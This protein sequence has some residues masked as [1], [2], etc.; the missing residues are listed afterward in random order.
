MTLTPAVIDKWSL[1]IIA[2]NGSLE[3]YISSVN[4]TPM[5]T[6]AE[7]LELAAR[8]QEHGDLHAAHHLVLS[9]LRVVVSVARSYAGYGL[10]HADL[11]QEGNIGLM[12]AVKRFDPQRGVRLFSFAIHWI[13]AEIHEFIL[14]N[15]RIVKVA[16]TKA[17]R[18]LFFNLR[19]AKKNLGWLNDSEA[20]AI[21]D[22]LGVPLKSVYEME[23]RL[24]AYDMS[25]DLDD[26]ADDDS[27]SAAPVLYLEDSRYD[28][29]Q[30]AEKDDY[31]QDSESQMAAAMEQLDERSRDIIER[32]WLNQ[33]SKDTL[34][35]L[36]DEY[37]VSA[38][39]IRQLEKAAMKKLKGLM[40]LVA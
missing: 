2:A 20:Q 5:L 35:S 39:R 9:H 16:T 38:E 10:Q 37:G 12:K 29:A 24:T 3:Q 26:D 40:T 19:S 11:I 32:R 4:I 36:A 34:Q 17:Q 25:F 8:L 30:M 33:E 13:K 31:Q 6:H 27:P 7:E 1:P 22:D 23:G 18:K 21:A 15:W 28:P 14:R